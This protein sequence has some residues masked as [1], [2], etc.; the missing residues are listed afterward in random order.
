MT[1]RG[2]AV[3]GGLAALGLV[4]AYTTWQREPERAAG[5][6]V[7]IDANKADL[8]NVHYEDENTS[9][10]IHGGSEVGE[11][12]VWLEVQDKTPVPAKPT[13]PPAKPAA[14]ESTAPNAA[15]PPPPPAAAKMRPARQLRGDEPA[16]KLMAAFAPLH[17]SRAFGVLDAAKVKELGLDKAKKKLVVTAR[18]ETREFVIGQP[19]QSSG[20]SYLRDVKDGRTYLMPRQVLTDLQGAAFRLVDRK[21]HTFKIADVD[22]LTVTAAG[23][24]REFVVSNRQDQ[25][26]Y[27]LAPKATPD[28]PDE[29][30]RNWHDKI[31]RL[32]PSDLLGKG[33]SPAGGQ[34]KVVARID[35]LDGDKNVGWLELAKV[36]VPVAPEPAASPH[37]VAASNNGVEVY[38][39]TEHTAGW[40]RL[41]ND[42]GTLTDADKIAAGS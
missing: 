21:L 1:G 27:K 18:G 31:W 19:P 28:K 29:M 9:I 10:D 3:Q 25:A 8:K 17:S 40:V 39:R 35:Y 16:E 14:T 6:I 26:A 42:P 22:R 30:A 33:E 34:P 41:H 7:V 37:A 32:F 4:I 11:S 2:L 23:K 5:D 20:E 38:G 13:T 15:T 36:E 24:T 12:G